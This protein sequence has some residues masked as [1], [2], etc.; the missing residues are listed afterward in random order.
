M[1]QLIKKLLVILLKT[2]IIATCGL[3][4]II[5]LG[6]L[7]NLVSY[8]SKLIGY[9]V[10]PI[11]SAESIG[12]EYLLAVIQ[13]NRNYITQEQECLHSTLLQDI[14]QYGGADVQNL[15]ITTELHSG[16]GD[17]HFEVTWVKFEYRYST[18]LP[19]KPSEIRLMT[20]TNLERKNSLPD[21][22]PFRRI[23]CGGSAF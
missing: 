3:L 15:A 17:H 20:A 21:A 8:R 4:G 23:V 7:L 14:T 1:V 10:L 9:V 22:L 13:K 2:G 18:Q 11:P 12:R 6:T 19:W 5:I 16:N